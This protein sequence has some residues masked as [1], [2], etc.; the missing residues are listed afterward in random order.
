MELQL[1]IDHSLHCFLYWSRKPTLSNVLG[2]N[3]VVDSV[4]CLC[5]RKAD[6]KYTKVALQARV[7]CE[8]SCCGVHACHILHISNVL[9]SQLLAVI[10]T[11]KY[12]NI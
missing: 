1:C 12:S 6:C 3:A 5:P 8:A 10:P 11:W 7:D 4:Q 9:Q 2:E